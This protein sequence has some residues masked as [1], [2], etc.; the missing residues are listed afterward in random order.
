MTEPTSSGVEA[1]LSP[2]DAS[3][4]ASSPA[5]ASVWEDFIDIF[6]APSAVFA[7]RISS[8]FL[9]PMLVVT[10]AGGVL[11]LVNSNVMSQVMDAEMTRA[12]AKQARTLTPEQIEGARKIGATMAKIG[13]F[14][15]APIIMFLTGLAL[16]VV[17][18][19]F[20]AK[21]TLGQAVMVA[22]YAYV[23]RILE[24]VATSVQGLLLDP[25]Q[26]TGRWRISLGVG[27]FLDPDTTSPALLALLGRVDVFTIWVTVLLVIGLSV[28]GKIPRAKAAIAG[29]IV[30]FLGAVPLL[31]QAR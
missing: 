3:P 14:V 25:A 19:F 7:R 4:A 24:G 21:Q 15:F 29:V 26:F 12:M 13:V 8:G 10:I 5:S 17:G 23:P 16:W 30:W 11:Y 28:T 27:R 6:Y 22:S 20:E 2:A 18:K 31:L 9:I 1:D